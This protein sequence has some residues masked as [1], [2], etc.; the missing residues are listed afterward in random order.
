MT[1]RKASKL[2]FPN[3]GVVPLFLF[4]RLMVCSSHCQAQQPLSQNEGIGGAEEDR[5]KAWEALG[6]HSGP[7]PWNFRLGGPHHLTGVA[8]PGSGI[9]EFPDSGQVATPQPHIRLGM[10]GREASRGSGRVA[11]EMPRVRNRE[12][13]W[14]RI[15]AS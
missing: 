7:M 6:L 13:P 5:I 2:F 10:C 11:E 14:F 15:Q 4:L 12:V 8:F 1:S 3:H 9:R